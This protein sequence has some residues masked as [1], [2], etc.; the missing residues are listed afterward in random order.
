MEAELRLWRSSQYFQRHFP[1]HFRLLLVLSAGYSGYRSHHELVN[2]RVLG[3]CH[4]RV[5][6]VWHPWT[7]AVPR[8]GC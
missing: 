2:R 5:D 1:R 3:V 8:T 4:P 7:K 6:M